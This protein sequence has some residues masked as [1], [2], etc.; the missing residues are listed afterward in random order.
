MRKSI[1]RLTN[2]GRRW[3]GNNVIQ[4]YEQHRAAIDK[5]IAEWADRGKLIEGGWQAYIAFGSAVAL[6]SDQ[7]LRDMRKAYMLG[8]QHLF[9]SV[10]MMLDPGAEP[11]ERDMK[12]MSMIHEE[13]EAFRRSLGN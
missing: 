8:A 4:Q 13:L 7:H 12:R 2:R 9:A 3:K 10:V 1:F 11:T 5:I 6:A